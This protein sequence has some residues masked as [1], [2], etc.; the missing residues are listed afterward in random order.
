[1]YAKVRFSI[2]INKN[3]IRHENFTRNV[4]NFKCH[5][6]LSVILITERARMMIIVSEFFIYLLEGDF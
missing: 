3:L 6:Q 2:K 5:N 1:M 4:L